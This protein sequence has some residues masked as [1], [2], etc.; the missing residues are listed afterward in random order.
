MNSLAQSRPPLPTGRPQFG[1]KAARRRGGYGFTLLEILVAMLVA[2]LGIL[3]VVALNVVSIKLQADSANRAQAGQY[4][5]DI[6]DRMR[7]NKNQA[8]A[9]LYDR[10][11]GTLL[12]APVQPAP[13]AQQDLVAW[14]T[15]LQRE[16]P[17]GDAAVLVSSGG[18]VSVTIQWFERQNRGSGAGNVSFTFSSSL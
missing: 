6:L 13:L 16:L 1:S 14:L 3:G 9:G 4:A 15:N 11:P 10:R 8:V 18:D 5:Q 17:S 2:A 12:P 7:A